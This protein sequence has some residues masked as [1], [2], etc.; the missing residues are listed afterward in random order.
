MRTRAVEALMISDAVLCAPP[1]VRDWLLALLVCGEKAGRI[2]ASEGRRIEASEGRRIEA[3][4]RRN[5]G[6]DP[7]H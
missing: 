1:V 5:R 6:L 3:S 7:R 4:G 2:E